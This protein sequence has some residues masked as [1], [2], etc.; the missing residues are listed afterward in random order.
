MNAGAMERF[1]D[2]DIAQAGDDALVKQQQLDRR[3]PP[4]QPALQL[5]RVEVQRLG[6]ERLEGRPFRKLRGQYQVERAEAPCVIEREG[7]PLLGLDQ[8]MVMLAD[9]ARVDAPMT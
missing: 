5:V 8:E 1:T 3:R 9:L 7:P 6:T 2:V 4:C